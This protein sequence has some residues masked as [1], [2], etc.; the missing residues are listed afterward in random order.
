MTTTTTTTITII[1][2]MLMFNDG[3]KTDHN[4]DMTMGKKLRRPRI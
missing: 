1:I 2:M 4:D 3:D